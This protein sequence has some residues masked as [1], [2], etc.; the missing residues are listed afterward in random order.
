[1]AMRTQNFNQRQNM[2]G[3]Q[4]E[5][6]HYRDAKMEPVNIHHHDFYEVYFYMG[7][8][9]SYWVEGKTYPLEPGDLLL[10]SPM[11]LHQP[12][13]QPGIV[14]ERIV[15]W[16]DRNY[17]HSIS[18]PDVDLSGCFYSNGSEHTNLL[19]P[20]VVARRHIYGLLE[21]LNREV[22]GEDFGGALYAQTLL[23]QLMLEVNRLVA[24][25]GET[26]T[27]PDSSELASQIVSY[28]NSHWHE[29]ISLE[30]LAKEF[31]VSKYYLSHE[32]SRQTGTGVYRYVTLK[33]LMMAKEML[34]AGNA[35]GEVYRL[36]GFHNYTNFYRAFKA[37][38]GISPQTA[39]KNASD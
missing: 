33:R 12:I 27:V 8:E 23:I 25:E 11:E 10:I 16:V 17:L 13:V 20:P 37:E 32:F 18:G 15:L 26:V 34:A 31:F 2:S 9:V 35:P 5:V 24:G 7:G 3:K 19:R 14:Y 39:G 36:C 4:F 30:K 21:Q 6:F 28:I 38:Y 29:D 1:V 22:Y